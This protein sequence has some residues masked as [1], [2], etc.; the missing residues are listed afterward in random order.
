MPSLLQ[1]FAALP[2]PIKDALAEISSPLLA[3]LTALDIA[4]N[5]LQVERMSC[6]EIVACLEAAGVAFPKLSMA[7]ALARAHPKVSVSRNVDGEP[8]YKLMTKGKRDV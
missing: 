2:A 8:T 7:R 4:N 5:E 6:E 1:V 3:G